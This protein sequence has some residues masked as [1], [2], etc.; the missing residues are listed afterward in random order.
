MSGS[1][2]EWK[3]QTSTNKNKTRLYKKRIQALQEEVNQQAFD[4]ELGGREQN[5]TVLQKKNAAMLKAMRSQCEV[6]IHKNEQYRLR[7]SKLDRKINSKTKRLQN[8]LNL[9]LSENCASIKELINKKEKNERSHTQRSD[10]LED[11]REQ[12]RQHTPQLRS[13][14]RSAVWQA[15]SCGACGKLLLEPAVAGCGAGRCGGCPCPCCPGSRPR[16][17]LPLRALVAALEGQLPPG[18]REERGRAK[19]RWEEER[20]RA[21]E[22]RAREADLSDTDDSF[23]SSD[24]EAYFDMPWAP[25]RRI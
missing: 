4:D 10:A 15:L 6:A 9:Q 24:S 20:Q 23:S 12:L 11:L 17:A 2:T 5:I 16:P 14:S 22:R 3:T 8:K 21:E 7:I 18:E 1:I 19:L 25:A 13:R